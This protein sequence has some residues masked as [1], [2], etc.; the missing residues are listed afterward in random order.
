MLYKKVN[1]N[2]TLK[3]ATKALNG[4]KYSSTLYLTSALDGDGGQRQAPTGRTHGTHCKR[5]W[6]GPRDG[7]GKSRP[8]LGFDLRTV[9]SVASCYTD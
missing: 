8:S 9:Q 2:V 5:D 7:R 3:W 4:V 1:V 6:V